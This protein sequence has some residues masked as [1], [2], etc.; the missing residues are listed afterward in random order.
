MRK[1]VL[2]TARPKTLYGKPLNGAMLGSLAEAYVAAINA[3]GT[4]TISTAWDRVVDTQC[5]D[6]VE[7]AARAY[8]ESMHTLLAASAA[9]PAT[10]QPPR[11][12]AGAAQ[13]L[14]SGRSGAV[15]AAESTIVEDEEMHAAHASSMQAALTY[16]R[17]HA[18]QDPERTPPYETRLRTE[19]DTAHARIRAANEAASSAFCLELLERLQ[20][21]A[22]KRVSALRRDGAAAGSDGAVVTATSVAVAYREASDAV[23]VHFLSEARG[24]AKSRALAEFLLTRLPRT[25]SEAAAVS[26]ESYAARAAA[27][28]ARVSDLGQQLAAARGRERSSADALEQER[29][30]FEAA[31]A[32]QARQ[33]AEAV[34]RL[35]GAL[36]SRTGE[37]DRL[38]TRYDHLLA[39]SEA[40][41]V[42]ADEAAAASRADLQAAFKRLDELQVSVSSRTLSLQSLRTQIHSSRYVCLPQCS[43]QS[44]RVGQLMEVAVLSQKLAEAEVARA[45][46]E[47]VAAELRLSLAE[48][49]RAAALMAVRTQASDFYGSGI[50]V[51]STTRRYRAPFRLRRTRQC[52]FAR[53]RSFCMRAF[54]SRRTFF[55]P[56]TTKRRSASTSGESR[57]LLREYCPCVRAPGGYKSYCIAACRK[58]KLAQVESE[59]LTMEADLTIMTN[60]ASKLKAAVARAAKG[61]VKPPALDK[62]E[63]RVFDSLDS[64]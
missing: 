4:P 18:V 37:L 50:A 58:A 19:I 6:A 35:K 30:S 51:L 36:E 31:L 34:E 60:V 14:F 28:D 48:E 16:F 3:G 44:T 21:L 56:R 47:R 55:S 32:T 62:V 24:P 9:A 29:R 20:E 59:R 64:A 53:T 2:T 23:S 63:Q 52:A 1:R 49:S 15:Y 41:R 13:P 38:S 54:V 5:A 46:V 45:G 27:A 57:E 8:I 40:Q 39:T 61:A 22:S 42:R 17:V 43:E 11:S 7:G 26:D 33:E 10:P 12:S 25:L